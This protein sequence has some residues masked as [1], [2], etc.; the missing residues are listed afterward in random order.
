MHRLMARL[1]AQQAVCSKT[2]SFSRRP[3]PAAMARLSY[4]TWMQ[5]QTKLQLALMDARSAL[6]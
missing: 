5:V 1:F 3:A 2:T 6:L 4:V